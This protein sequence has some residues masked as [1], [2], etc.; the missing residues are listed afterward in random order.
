MGDCFI[1]VLVIGTVVVIGLLVLL[2]VYISGLKKLTVKNNNIVMA[3]LEDFQKLVEDI[4]GATRN[5]TAYIQQTG[6]T[7]DQQDQVLKSLQDAVV[8]LTSVVPMA[9]D[10][11]A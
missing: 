5:I 7:A 4:N 1:G 8:G 10:T 2:L 9:P 6:L 11:Q 3:K